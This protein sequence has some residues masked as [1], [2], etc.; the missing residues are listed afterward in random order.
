LPNLKDYADLMQR[1]QQAKVRHV[2]EQRATIMPAVLD[3]THKAQMIVDHPGWQFFLDKIEERVKAVE[4]I[5]ATKMHAMVF[6][7]AMG[8]DLELLKIELNTMDAEIRALRYAADLVPQVIEV[9][10]TFATGANGSAA[11]T[12]NAGSRA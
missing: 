11:G 1:T 6:G 5:R 3:V 4:S 2:H 9:G 10:Q 12:S 8:H 7:N